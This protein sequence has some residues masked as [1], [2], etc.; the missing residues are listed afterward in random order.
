MK[1]NILKNIITLLLKLPINLWE[2]LITYLPGEAGFLFRYRYWKK[3][4][5]QLGTNA[6]INVGVYFQKPEFI[7]IDDNCLVDRNVVILAGPPGT[8]RITHFI[9]NKDFSLLKGEVYI[10]KNSHIAPNCVLSGIGGL[11]IGKNCGIASNSSV[12][13]FSH[14]YRNLTDRKDNM[15]YS[16]TPMARYDQQS[17]ISGPVAI[18]DYSAVG[19][20]SVI[21]PGT[22]IKKGSWISSGSIVTGQYPKQTLLQNNNQPHSKKLKLFIKE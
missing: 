7:S 18:E 11:Y 22:S 20:N 3:R 6:R 13:S 14:H 19:L 21:L 16:F 10:G 5:K 15:Q 9:D 2:M 12:Y 1:M 8:E 4:L 17:M